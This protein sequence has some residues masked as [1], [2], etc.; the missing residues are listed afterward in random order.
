MM[1]LPDT[2]TKQ[3]SAMPPLSRNGAVQDQFHHFERKVR[4]TMGSVMP[5]VASR[6]A[7]KQLEDAAQDME[8]LSKTFGVQA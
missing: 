7:V 4:S 6:L 2:K 3:A 1:P 5:M 8:D